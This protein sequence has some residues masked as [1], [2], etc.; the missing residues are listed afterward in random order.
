[1][2]LARRLDLA[3]EH[4][5]LLGREAVVTGALA[6]HARLHHGAQ[7]ALGD[8]R[9][10]DEARHLLLLDHL[11]VDVGLDVGMIDVDDHHLGGAA[12][13]AARLDGAGGAVT[14]LEEAHQAGRLAAA[15]QP[16]ALAAQAGEVGAGA[17]AVLEQPRLAHPQIH[18]AA[19]VDE[20]VL[21]RLDEAGVRLRM[22]VG[23]LGAV[24]L[25]GLEVDVVVAL[26]RAV[27]AVGPVQA[28]V[29]PLRRVRRHHLRGQHVA[30]LVEEG[31]RIG[32]AIEIATLPAPVG[33]GAGE[34]VEHLAGRGLAAEALLL[35]QGGERR[36][37]GRRAPQPGR[38]RLLL[39]LLQVRR[40]ARLA[41]V[42]LGEHVG[43]DLRPRRRHLDR[44]G[45]EHHRAVRVADLAGGGAE[46]DVRIGG[47]AVFG[48]APLDPHLQ[49][50]ALLRP[51][52]VRT[53]RRH[54]RCSQARRRAR[55]TPRLPSFR[56][57]P[58]LEQPV[59]RGA[60]PV[61]LR[62]LRR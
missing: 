27:D 38:N 10:G 17:G 19:L 20:V 30:Q 32:L 51:P 5:V 25:A 1:M 7:M 31:V 54:C 39:D 2:V 21:D 16:L 57:T 18:D 45:T 56:L 9:A 29:E 4:R 41:E 59:I 14:D 24:H 34:P 13:G 36:L 62:V 26:A 8:A 46:R 55:T 28:G 3:L 12:R 47:L 58:S 15:R 22:L 6:V 40:D 53:S 33:P 61:S 49:P 23:R 44:V 37:V 60:V 43:G 11:P 50:L 48:V 35:G 52:S 42:L